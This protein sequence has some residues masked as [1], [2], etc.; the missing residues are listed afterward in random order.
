MAPSQPRAVLLAIT[1]LATPALGAHGRVP[2]PAGGVFFE[3]NLGQ[4]SPEVA[5]LARAGSSAV[6]LA[7]DGVVFHSRA[8]EA[9]RHG[10]PR[11]ATPA[12]P[13]G[14]VRMTLVGGRLA[15]VAADE[16]R[17]S[18]TNYFVG[19]DRS[20]WLRGVPNYGRVIYRGVY[21][22][23]DLVFHAERGQL[24]YDFVV[25]P[26]ADPNVIE[27][28]FEGQT[29][30][31]LGGN[32]DLIL[33][34][35]AGEL[36]HPR[37]RAFHEG[38]NGAREDV[39][40]EFV[41]RAGGHVG[42]RIGTFDRGRPL[43]IDPQVLWSTATLS[44]GWKLA[45]S[46]GGRT[47]SVGRANSDVVLVGLDVG[48]NVAWTSNFGGA[49]PDEGEDVALGPDG[50]VYVT[51][52][53][54]SDLPPPDGFSV[55]LPPGTPS[56]TAGGWAAKVL[57]LR[58]D[59]LS[60]N[61]LFFT[62]FGGTDGL[63]SPPSGEQMSL[64]D[65][66]GVAVDAQ[67]YVYLT[68]STSSDGF[69]VRNALVASPNPNGANT[70][71]QGWAAKLEPTLQELVYSTYLRGSLNVESTV[72]LDVAVDPWG[73]GHF[74]GATNAADYIRS[75]GA[76]DRT[77]AAYD[78][79]GF[80]TKVG[81]TG[82]LL[83]STYL[84]GATDTDEV[85]GVA[86]D[87]LGRACLTGRTG[88]T[89]FPVTTGPGPAGSTD[90]FATRLSVDGSALAYSRYIGGN[91]WDYGEAILVGPDDGLYVVGSTYST[92]WPG[93][94]GSVDQFVVSLTPAG[95]WDWNLTLGGTGGDQA[96][97]GAIDAAGHVYTSGPLLEPGGVV[98]QID[99]CGSGLDAACEAPT[100][101]TVLTSTTRWKPRRGP[102]PIS[103]DFS[104][105]PDLHLD[106][107]MLDIAGPQYAEAVY[108]PIQ[109]VAP[110]IYRLVWP[111]P[112]ASGQYRPKGNY[113]VTVRG[114]AGDPRRVVAS[115]P[116]GD[117]SLVEVSSIS[118]E[119]TAGA[120]QLTPNPPIRQ[121]GEPYFRPGGGLRIYAE[122]TSPQSATFNQVKVVVSIEPTVPVEVPVHLRAF[123]VDDPAAGP[124]D[125]DGDIG[126]VNDNRG[127]PKN[128]VLPATITVP[129]GPLGGEATFT[130]GLQ[131]G[132]NYRVVAS[133][134]QSWVSGIEA[135]ASSPEGK[136]NHEGEEVSPMLTVWRT[137]HVLWDG[138]L[139]PPTQPP[140]PGETDVRNFIMGSLD[141]ISPPPTVGKP[142]EYW[143]RAV[144]QLLADASKNLNSDPP[145]SGRFEQGKLCL[146]VGSAPS[147]TLGCTGPTVLPTAGNGN[148]YVRAQGVIPYTLSKSG[149]RTLS[150]TI[151]AFERAP[152][153]PETGPSTFDLDRQPANA[154]VGGTLVVAGMSW[155]V[156]SIEEEGLIRAN[157]PLEVP[158]VLVDDD[159]A[160]HPFTLN[161]R[162]LQSLDAHPQ[163]GLA[164]A[165]VTPV[166]TLDGNKIPPFL[167]N[168]ACSEPPPGSN[169]DCGAAGHLSQLRAGK[170]DLSISSPGYWKMYLQMAFQAPEKHDLDPQYD[171]WNP[172]PPPLGE[173]IGDYDEYGSLVYTEALWENSF[174][175]GTRWPDIFDE[176]NAKVAA[177]ELG[178]QFGLDDP[179][180][181][182]ALDTFMSTCFYGTP[183]FNGQ[184]Q[185]TIR[186][187]RQAC[188]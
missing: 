120:P 78:M 118:F 82:Q 105:P 181:P 112:S 40:V 14:R 3:P 103:V 141:R 172:S 55:G 17:A 167:R 91:S 127:V 175:M 2:V 173:T 20:R 157:G 114:E 184:E 104:G 161:P 86:I 10:A 81:P 119:S 178:H 37:P 50:S 48:G 62:W 102:E 44:E 1:F 68:G 188:Q 150:G 57:L 122:K 5:F 160:T 187:M 29:A 115:A 61:L 18:I 41:M 52:W 147:S 92:N 32:G 159:T 121:S 124:P 16:R 174:L 132:D 87:G 185:H 138:M 56:G 137:L 84:G 34:T 47:Y 168:I 148:L 8:E 156:Q 9:R 72:G 51:G 26:G 31:R 42:F 45:A 99:V 21:A 149:Q 152:E 30:L 125:M 59:Q 7:T 145:Y 63:G 128:G 53:T 100:E 96:W 106:S 46:P 134:D 74:V 94:H 54:Q 130:V 6:Y 177:H 133:T 146:G 66:R 67:G 39:A 79:T 12:E 27:L 69:P 65:G 111:A 151:E 77:N 126:P 33:G 144:G 176:C 117:I 25:A 135:L 109:P 90:T 180:D 64:D 36:R 140:G 155:T 107:G 113:S 108:A 131:P 182:T 75:D 98:T 95:V 162:Y 186:C 80:V 163:N 89:D 142:A 153:P 83:Y 123:D 136:L 23:V 43:V 73:S 4:A 139:P 110:G 35:P 129:P 85:V 49:R 166:T 93:Q 101:L 22:G 58:F 116:Y 15:D 97:G 60:G 164:L 38:D 158:F 170:D 183:Y 169:Q 143:L 24:E 154:Y 70:Y 76:F 88:S 71:F 19:P 179:P 11:G 171:G 165:Y 28:R 13:E